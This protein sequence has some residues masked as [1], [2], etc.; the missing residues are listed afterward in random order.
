MALLHIRAGRGHTD[1]RAP[2][3]PIFELETDHTA[4]PAKWEAIINEAWSPIRSTRPQ[5]RAL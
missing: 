4:M 3:S 5:R 1:M 2:L